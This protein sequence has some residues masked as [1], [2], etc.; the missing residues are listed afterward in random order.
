MET[1]LYDIFFLLLQIVVSIM[2]LN[3]TIKIWKLINH[4]NAWWIMSIGFLLFI[5]C[6]LSRM[7][8]P[9]STMWYGDWNVLYTPLLIEGAFTFSAYRIYIASKR[10]VEHRLAVEKK[11]KIN[12]SRIKELSAKLDPESICPHWDEIKHYCHRQKKYLKEIKSYRK[13]H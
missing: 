2:G 6:S 13:K 12:L 5:F 3:Y 4:G 9:H 7:F 8:V 10:E 1:T 11:V